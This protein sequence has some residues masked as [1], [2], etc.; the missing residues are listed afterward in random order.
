M[1]W[2]DALQRIMTLILHT[3]H[4]CRVPARLR[5]DTAP[6]HDF[7]LSTLL[8]VIRLTRDA[9]KTLMSTLSLR[10]ALTWILFEVELISCS[11]LPSFHLLRIHSTAC[12]CSCAQSTRW[13]RSTCTVRSAGDQSATCA[14]WED[15][16]PTTKSPP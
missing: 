16:T 7:F 4:I 2:H 15:P 8:F 11:L 9:L 14:S 10:K 1:R 5:F 13:R 12:R 3:L 6:S